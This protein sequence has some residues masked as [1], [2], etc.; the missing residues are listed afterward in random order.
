MSTFRVITTAIMVSGCGTAALAEAP[1]L[2]TPSPVIFLADNLDENQGLG[3]CIDTLGRG[4]AEELQTHSCKPQGGDVQFQ[5][6]ADSGQIQSV[7]FPD[8][9]M[10]LVDPA[11]E[12]VPFGLRDCDA[13][14]EAQKFSYSADTQQ[15]S[16]VSAPGDCVT[17]GP[18]SRQAGPFLSRDLTIVA[19]GEGDASLQAWVIQ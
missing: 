15:I 18:E 3:W 13:D 2:Q 16:L 4:Y 19:C 14:A 10:T 11:S 5:Y 9:C 12:A 17:A 6:L 1:Q 7:A 8:K